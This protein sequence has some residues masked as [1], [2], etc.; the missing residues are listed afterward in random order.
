MRK[1]IKTIPAELSRLQSLVDSKEVNAIQKN[2]QQ[3]RRHIWEQ[4]FP[5][6]PEDTQY[7]DL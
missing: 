2:M 4:F 3:I 6:S 1:G 5:D 7:Y